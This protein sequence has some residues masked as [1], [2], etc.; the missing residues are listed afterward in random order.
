MAIKG[1][2]SVAAVVLDSMKIYGH[3][4][5]E[6]RA[7]PDFRDGL[8]PVH[9]RLLWS[10]HQE[11]L[12]PT[13]GFRKSATLVGATM[14]SYHPHSDKGIYDALVTLVNLPQP[15]FQ[16][17]G[18]WGSVITGAEPAAFRYTEVRLNRFS[19]D[20]I[21]NPRYMPVVSTVPNFDGSKQE[22]VFL[23]ARLPIL[24]MTGAQGIA[25]G[26][27]TYVPSF[28]PA[29]LLKLLREAFARGVPT[30]RKYP[31]VTLDDCV[32]T[33]KFACATGGRVVSRK[34]EIKQMMDE[35]YGSIEWECVYKIDEKK[36]KITVTGLAPGWTLTEGRFNRLMALAS[37]KSVLDLSSGT[38]AKIEIELKPT[39]TKAEMEAAVST[40]SNHLRVRHTYRVN[41]T[42]R[43]VTQDENDLPESAAKFKSLSLPD[44]LNQ[45]I[46]WRVRL[47]KKAAE[48]EYTVLQGLYD[49]QKL[50][51][52][53]IDGLEVIFRLLRTPKIDK[54][55]ELAKALKITKEQ[56]A[57]IWAIAVGRLD[58]LSKEATAKE[59]TRLS[60]EMKRASIDIQRPIRAT[61]R[62]LDKA[63]TDLEKIVARADKEG[64]EVDA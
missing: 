60:E 53:A 15:L 17:A 23:P 7:V 61:T 25:V 2:K 8:K 29:S 42:E 38:G 59:M 50:L 57:E 45:W 11:G 4:T 16:G 33:L 14:G 30:G 55:I 3:K 43:Y 44:T 28:T 21:L 46:A 36:K 19:A 10:A 27:N 24:F 31:E 1:E 6:D 35:G 37:V 49:R 51:M 9:R 34:S 18:N 47:E 5:V 22:P 39:L 62:D 13:E 52:K 54:V 63:S 32:S 41:I 12:R 56:S 40:L 26:V 64:S 48:H 58:R 20:I